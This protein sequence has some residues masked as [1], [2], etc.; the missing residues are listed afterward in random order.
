MVNYA[1]PSRAPDAKPRHFRETIAIGL[2]DV[3]DY[4]ISGRGR[5]VSAEA[6]LGL[7]PPPAGPADTAHLKRE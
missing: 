2:L 6:A 4:F 5:R 3:L 1:E 7:S